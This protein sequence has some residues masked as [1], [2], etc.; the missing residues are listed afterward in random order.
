MSVGG[1]DGCGVSGEKNYEPVVFDK[2]SGRFPDMSV[3]TKTALKAK[4]GLFFFCA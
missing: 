2:T 1:G 3:A 4:Y